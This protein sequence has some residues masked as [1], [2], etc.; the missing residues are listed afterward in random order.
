MPLSTVI[1]TFETKPRIYVKEF[2]NSFWTRLK[3]VM[4]Y[5]PLEVATSLGNC[6]YSLASMSK[7]PSLVI[8]RIL[9]IILVK[10]TVTALAKNIIQ[11]S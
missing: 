11:T 8:M 4:T 2:D 9:Y 3:T 5:K 10:P 7:M 6:D 1:R